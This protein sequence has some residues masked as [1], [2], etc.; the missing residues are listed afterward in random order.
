MF[1]I[2]SDHSSEM[3]QLLLDAAV[4]NIRKK[5]HEPIPVN[6]SGVCWTCGEPVSDGRRWCDADCRDMADL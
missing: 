4:A 6:Q 5:S 1:E 2:D 3:E